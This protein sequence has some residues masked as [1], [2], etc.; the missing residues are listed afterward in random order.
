MGGGGD[1]A[2]PNPATYAGVLADPARPAADR[3]RDAAR[4]AAETLAFAQVRP[5]QRLADT[6]IGGGDFTRIFAAAVGPEGRVIAWQ[7]AEFIAFAA[8]YSVSNTEVD[9]LPNV[10][11]IRSST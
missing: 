2:M 6:I 1:M 9:A 4:H 3:K 5:G 8:K 11:A 10:D 7:S